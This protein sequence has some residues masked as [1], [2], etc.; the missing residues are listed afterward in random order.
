MKKN[1]DYYVGIDVSKLTLDVTVLFEYNNSTKTVYYKLEN[2]EKSIAQFVRKLL[3]SNES[4]QGLFCFEN[5]G[6]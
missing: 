4:G 2:S 5:T 3:V 6:I 1:F